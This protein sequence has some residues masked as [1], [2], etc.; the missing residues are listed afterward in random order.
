MAGVAYE[1]SDP[2][3]SVELQEGSLAE[4]AAFKICR[5]I[6]TGMIRDGAD[7]EGWLEYMQC[8]G[9]PDAD[10]PT[11]RSIGLHWLKLCER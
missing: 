9:V 2:P 1:I 7:L 5:R 4:L 11:L 10:L 3:G 6:G 8:M